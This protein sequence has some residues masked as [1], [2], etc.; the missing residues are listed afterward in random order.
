M[1][2]AEARELESKNV[3]RITNRNSHGGCGRLNERRVQVYEYKPLNEVV[4]P[5]KRFVLIKNLIIRFN[6]K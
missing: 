2:D 4:S 3:D 6:Y 5:L 1:T